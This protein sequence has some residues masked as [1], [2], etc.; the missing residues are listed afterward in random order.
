VFKHLDKLTVGDKI[1]VEKGNGT[2]ISY[3]VIKT[4]IANV[5][6]VDMAKML[7]PVT[8]GKHGLNLIS[9]TGTYNA[10]TKQYEQRV[11]IFAEVM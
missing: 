7:L 3:R 8:A 5:D 2:K 10:Q 11:M 6:K 1:V 9:C 4:E